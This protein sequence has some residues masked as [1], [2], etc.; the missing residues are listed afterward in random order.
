MV[1][2]VVDSLVV[3]IGVCVC[4]CVCVVMQS[5]SGRDNLF[6]LKRSQSILFSDTNY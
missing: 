6:N 4:V 2:D 1:G 5:L 3:V